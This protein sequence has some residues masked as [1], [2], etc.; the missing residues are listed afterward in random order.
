M[1]AACIEAIEIHPAAE[2]YADR[3][4]LYF[5]T[6]NPSGY[7]SVSVIFFKVFVKK[8]HKSFKKYIFVPSDYKAPSSLGSFYLKNAAFI[9]V[10]KFIQQLK[11]MLT[12]SHFISP[13]LIQVGSFPFPLFFLFNF[14]I[15]K[16]LKSSEKNY[17]CP[18]LTQIR[19]KS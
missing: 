13:P 17:F 14:F 15:K 12:A 8:A 1:D 16:A 6:F 19:V 5:T 9:K 7:I 4:T 2:N 3:L 11:T 10:L 18:L